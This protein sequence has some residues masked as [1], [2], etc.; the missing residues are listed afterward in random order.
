MT[1]LLA[2][3][4]ALS[5]TACA[6]N[7]RPDVCKYASVRRAVYTTTIRAAD[8]Y[9]LSGRIVPYEIALGRRAAE[10]ALAVLDTNCPE[11]RP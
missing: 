1:R 5:L 8:L 2:L 9:A 4:A 11:A 3:A 6:G 10:T 7:P